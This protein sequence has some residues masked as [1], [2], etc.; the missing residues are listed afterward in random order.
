MLEYVQYEKPNEKGFPL[1]DTEPFCIY[2]KKV[3]KGA[4]LLPASESEGSP[5][6]IMRPSIL[7]R[8]FR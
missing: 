5:F 7:P 3:E 8:L 6:V 2:T 4:F 1:R